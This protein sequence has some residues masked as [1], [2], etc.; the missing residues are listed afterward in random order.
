MVALQEKCPERMEQWLSERLRLL[1]LEIT[2]YGNVETPISLNES[3]M[4]ALVTQWI[5][6]EIY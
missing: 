2:G 4:R 3:K 6:S 1:N 5:L